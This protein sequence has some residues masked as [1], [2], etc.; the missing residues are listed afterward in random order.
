M[1]HASGYPTSARKPRL[2]GGASLPVPHQSWKRL[3]LG[4]SFGPTHGLTR[5]RGGRNWSLD[6]EEPNSIISM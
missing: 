3:P 1:E 2:A 6:P 5:V 4:K